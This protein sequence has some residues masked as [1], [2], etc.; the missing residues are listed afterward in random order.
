MSDVLEVAKL[1]ASRLVAFAQT[2]P[3]NLEKLITKALLG[4]GINELEKI[5]NV[6]SS[7]EM[8][9][10]LGGPR[11]PGAMSVG[12]HVTNEIEELRRALK[13]TL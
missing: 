10:M 4:F 6:V 12:V 1:R 5:G 7:M 8:E 11:Q 2:Q 13:E 9:Q 3:Q